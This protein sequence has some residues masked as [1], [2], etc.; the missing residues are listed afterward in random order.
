MAQKINNMKETYL[1]RL[2]DV[3]LIFKGCLA[4]IETVGG[5]LAFFVSPQFVIDFVTSIT[6]DELSN[7]PNDFFSNFLM[8]SAQQ[9]SINSQH[10]IAFYL[11][12]H[13]IIKGFLIINLFKEKLWAYPL[14]MT[15]FSLF[16]VY[17]LFEFSRTHSLWLLALTVLD[18]AVIYLTLHEYR[19]MKKTG[20]K[21]KWDVLS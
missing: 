13:G 1:H 9:L 3:S 14:A 18:A 12:S 15:V 21:P 17:Q 11:L 19:F 10:F 2:F 4:A 7:D 6:Q 8:H 20:T 5:F 16:G